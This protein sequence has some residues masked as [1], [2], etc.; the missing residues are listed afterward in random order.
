MCCVWEDYENLDY[1]SARL[2]CLHLDIP[3]I[4]S[5]SVS[6]LR[7][8]LASLMNLQTLHLSCGFQ[9]NEI[10]AIRDILHGCTNDVLQ[11]FALCYKNSRMGEGDV[12]AIFSAFPRLQSLSL[13]AQKLQRPIDV[14][15]R[16]VSSLRKSRIRTVTIDT[17][18]KPL[19]AI[20]LRGEME[21]LDPGRST[22]RELH[23]TSKR[24]TMVDS[25]IRPRVP[26]GCNLV[27]KRR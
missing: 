16:L 23:L 19:H 9:N 15:R 4:T 25:I 22:L 6:L 27:V 26:N 8:G 13:A 11:T 12:V 2:R 1:W 5:A 3:C 24:P 21:R 18:M 20:I 10:S 14:Y 17:P 7:G